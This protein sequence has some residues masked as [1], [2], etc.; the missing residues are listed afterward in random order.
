MPEV[1]RPGYYAWRRRHA[2]PSA[3]RKRDPVLQVALRKLH[4]DHRSVYGSSRLTVAAKT[5]GLPIGR[6][7]TARPMRLEGLL[8]PCWS[9]PYSLQSP[10]P[11][12]ASPLQPETPIINDRTSFD[13]SL[14]F[15]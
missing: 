7:A 5:A 13:G 14:Q 10:K 1:S 8:G 9:H 4:A 12:Q 11:P 6:R 3:R 2:S 15:A